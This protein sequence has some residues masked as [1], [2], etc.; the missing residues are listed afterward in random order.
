MSQYFT[1]VQKNTLPQFA[2]LEPNFGSSD[3]H[4]G[5]GQSLLTGQQ[6]VANIINALM[7]SP[8][9]SDSVFFFSFDEA[10]GPYDHVPPVPGF[11]NQNTTAPL[12]SVEG[13]VTPIAVNPDGFL[14]CPPPTPGVY[15]N[16]CDVRPNTPGANPADAPAQSGFAAQI[17]FR[18]PNLIIS[19]FVK[20]HYVGHAAMD[21]TA[22]AHFLEQRFN[23]PALT[24]RDAA[25][26]NLLDFFDFTNKPW[27]TPPPQAEVPVPPAVGG[28]CHP[29]SFVP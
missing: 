16:H 4:P 11:T 23:L 13:D 15:N 24:K 17:G 14:P 9:W 10:G 2:F 25:Q 5:S 3:E 20:K 22:V 1:D 18:V 21:H 28:T 7:F 8:S 27:A 12:V 19:P 6:Q 29:T 26:P